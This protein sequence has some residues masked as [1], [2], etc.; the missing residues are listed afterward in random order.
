MAVHMI[1]EEE[2]EGEDKETKEEEETIEEGEERGVM[3]DPFYNHYDGNLKE[4]E[5]VELREFYSRPL[6]FEKQQVEEII[7]VHVKGL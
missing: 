1:K 2:S 7:H 6:V 3:N 5:V 4:S